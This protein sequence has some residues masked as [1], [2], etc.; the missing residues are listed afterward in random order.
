MEP[1]R[2]IEFIEGRKFVTAVV[3]RDKGA[4]VLVLSETDREMSISVNRIL[5]DCNKGLNPE[6][7]RND[8]VNAL[9]ETA[10]AR[11]RLSSEVDI[12]ELWELLEDEGES[13]T[14]QFLTELNW[15]GAI[16]PDHYAAV[17]RAV[18]ADGLYF[19]MRP[20]G[21]F[22]HDSD[23][24]EQIALER[25]RE[26]QREKDL[27][28][29]GAW[30][31]GVWKDDYSGEPEDKDRFISVLTEMAL[32]GNEAPDYKFGRKLIEKAGLGADP[33]KP[34][35][36]LVKLGEMN[37]H[38]NLD[39]RRGEVLNRFTPEILEEAKRIASDR[40]WQ[41]EDRRDLT[42]LEVITADSGGAKDFDD[43]VSLEIKGDHLV[44]GVHIAD[45]SAVVK[46]DSPLDKD[47]RARATSIYMPDLRIPMMPEILSE[48]CLSLRE[49]EVRPAFSLLVKMSGEGEILDYEFTPSLVSVKRQL[50]YQEVDASVDEDL[51]LKRLYKISKALRDARR[52]N[53]AVILSLPK[54]NVFLTPEGEIG[55]NLTQWE[56]PGRSMISEFMILAN[57][58]GADYLMKQGECCLYRSQKEPSER[59][60]KTE[61]D[62][63]D[64][65]LCL[66]QRRFLNRVSWG[67]GPSPHASMGVHLYT[68][69]TS[70]L[71]RYIDLIIQRQIR[72]M[73][74][75]NRPFYSEDEVTSILSEVDEVLRKAAIVQNNRR[76]Y[77]LYRYFEGPGRKDYE[78]LVLERYSHRWRIFL[79][80]LMMDADLPFRQGMRLDPGDTIRVRIK[81]VDARQDVFVLEQ[82]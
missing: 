16:T 34:F 79:T 58:L 56:N 20:D 7:P 41:D 59:I 21:A 78:A 60:L 80:E 5:H 13:F 63:K 40:S 44:L 32:Y 75:E 2:V 64:L 65:F 61:A 27:E 70:P 6:Q 18:F 30:L 51:V 55:V 8:L 4:K 22:R 19:K 48:E 82:V 42:G 53:G 29:G 66:R 9:K 67:T 17:I 39:I 74:A 73:V 31:A 38:E 43:A 69:L 57:Q 12:Y 23:K 71:R 46:A 76:R 14:Y 47:S 72:T 81:K 1:G 26:E 68:N 15:T 11:M 33:W 54:L 24:V 62:Y 36:L 25:A 49:G 45:V 10:A 3:T 28:I 35:D 50:S 77:W 37:L 52:A